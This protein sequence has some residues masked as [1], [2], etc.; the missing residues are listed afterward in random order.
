[1]LRRERPGRSR[2]LV[3]VLL[4]VLLLVACSRDERK[5]SGAE[6][7]P[8]T[9]ET[10]TAATPAT[11]TQPAGQ[12]ALTGPAQRTGRLQP[13]ACATFKVQDQLADRPVT[14][15]YLT[16][17]EDRGKPDG[18]T[19]RLAVAIFKA[20]NAAPGEPPLVWLEGGPGGA[21]IEPMAK[22]LTGPEG[23]IVLPGRSLVAD[24]DLVLF[25]QRG[26]GFSQPSLACP[27]LAPFA[28]P[29]ADPAPSRAAALAA[30]VTAVLACRD[31]LAAEGVD[32]AA[33]TS[34]ENA[35]D[36]NDLR[37]ALG[38]DRVN[39]YGVS[40]G[41][42]LA[43]TVMRDF[44]QTV[45]SAVLDSAVPLQA[46]LYADAFTSAQRAFD[47]LFR[48]CA[49]DAACA[50]AYPDLDAVF[51]ALIARLN[52]DPVQTTSRNPLTREES[53]A[54][55]TGD[56]MAVAMFEL[57]YY[58]PV[59]PLAPALIYNIRDGNLDTFMLLL[60]QIA[61]NSQISHAMHY[62]VQCGE[63]AP[64]NSP[65]EVAAGRQAARP[66]LA[67]ALGA[68]FGDQ[69][70]TVCGAWPARPPNPVETAPAQSAVPTLVLSGSND[71]ITPPA[72]AELAAATL[73]NSYVFTFPAVGHGAL[74]SLQTCPYDITWAFWKNPTARPD[75]GCTA[76]MKTP[77]WLVT[78]R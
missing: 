52:A 73:P 65:A 26:T 33:Y 40:Y 66:E 39:L 18:R 34:V 15:G 42:R 13:V 58:T 17:P 7:A 62:S 50:R 69:T 4:T 5:D 57:L 23:R 49:A 61:E 19:I 31:R 20:A 32:L 24:R 41:T 64:F 63:E 6:R 22:V 67:Q 46:D 72:Y 60:S 48:G 21:S 74:L 35:A 47:L 71:P 54:I 43:L 68:V 27:D 8:A 44:P 1:M 53:P 25:D 3:L 10:S 28:N 77:V 11:A 70:A 56:S 38:Y 36:V 29:A 51:Y 76:T 45:R 55:I 30:Q 12:P 2:W 75:G 14:C 37:V 78:R 16:V 9:P 59:L